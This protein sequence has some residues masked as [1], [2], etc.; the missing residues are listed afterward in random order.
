M[1]TGHS[2]SFYHNHRI[3]LLHNIPP[4]KGPLPKKLIDKLHRSPVRPS[5]STGKRGCVVENN[6]PTRHHMLMPLFPVLLYARLRVVTIYEQ[7]VNWAAPIL[8]GIGAKFFNPDH[9]PVPAA[10]NRPMCRAPCGIDS[11]DATE[12]EGVNQPEGPL[13]RHGLTQ[14]D[15]GRAFCDTDLDESGPTG[16]PFSQGLMFA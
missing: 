2:R 1:T 14:C 7:E 8:R 15:G 3:N 13:G 6:H 11:P 9:A 4:R 10:S 16:C 5:P 12:M